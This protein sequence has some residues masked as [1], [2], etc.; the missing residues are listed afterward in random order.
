MNLHSEEVTQKREMVVKSYGAPRESEKSLY[1]ME[2]QDL[3]VRRPM[4]HADT[5]LPMENER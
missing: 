4:A 5:H 3:P 2:L 1:S